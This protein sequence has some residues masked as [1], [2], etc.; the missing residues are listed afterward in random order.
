MQ[1]IDLKAQSD[2]IEERLLHRFKTVLNHG[3]YIMGPEIVELEN[4]LARFVGVKHAL[5]V[6]SGTDALLIALM[7]L[8]IKAGDEVITT[9]FS[10][11]AT[12]EVIA[13]LG[14][15]PVFV[16]IDK[17]TYN[18]NVASIEAAI[19]EKT[20]AIMPVS[21]YGQC[22]DFDE[23]NTI[24]K[25][26]NLPV[27]EDAAQSFG[28]T[29]KGQPSCGLTTIGCTSFFPSK[30]LGCYG[31]G[32]ACFT[33]DS[34]LAQRM[35]EIRTHGQSKRY[36]HTRLGI[37]GRLDTIQAAILLEKLEIF[38]EE[39]QLRQKVAQQYQRLLPTAIK[40]PLTKS[41]N[42]SVYAQYTV[43]VAN[44]DQVQQALHEKG[45]PTAVHYPLGLHE[46]PIFKELYPEKQSFPNTEAAARRVMSIPMHPYLTLEDQKQ[47]C[48]ALQEV[49]SKEMAIA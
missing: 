2:R 19:N 39:I 45:I 13:L 48:E 26:Y 6:A 38:P 10:F 42:L 32:G 23:I 28:A 40:K 14:A 16:D 3:S 22:A 11:F 46:Q 15:K 41:H 27:I 21:L 25:R 47:I 36:Y 43:E 35:N 44:R 34:E 49:L 31:D 9:P 12:A 18:I 7:A 17:E 5:A 30:P 8:G 33:N 24:A 1:F 29:Y 37:N 20:K 4:A